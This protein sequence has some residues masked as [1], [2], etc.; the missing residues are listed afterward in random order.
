MLPDFGC[1]IHDLVFAPNNAGTISL[2]TQAVR[3]ALTTYERAHR[4]ARRRR[5]RSPP[6]QPNLLLIRVS[7]RIRANN[8]IGQSRLPVLHPRGRV[9]HAARASYLP[10][11]DDR[12]YDDIVAEIRTRIARYTPEWR[13]GESAW[14]D[15]NDSDPGITIAQVF[16]WQAEMLLYR[17]NKVPALN[18]I[19]FLELI[20]IELQPAEP[21]Q[22]EITFPLKADRPTPT[23]V[24]V[25]SRARSSRPIPATASRRSSS[26]PFAPLTA[27]RAP[28]DAVLVKE[29]IDYNDVS[30][31]NAD[32]THGFAPFGNTAPDGAELALGFNDPDPFPES[33]LDLAV[34]VQDRLRPAA[35]S[36]A[37]VRRR[38]L[39]LRRRSCT[40]TTGTAPRWV[41]LKLLKDD[42]LAFTRSGHVRL[43]LPAAGSLQKLQARADANRCTLLDS[44]GARPRAVRESAVD[45][46]GP[47]EHRRRQNRPRRCTTR[48]SAEAT[49][50]AIRP[51]SCRTHR[52]S[53]ARCGS[54]FSR[55]MSAS[56][57]GRRSR[58]SSVPDQPTRSTSSIARQ[59]TILFGDGVNGAIPVAYVNNP[60]ANVVA[61]E[62]T[63]RRWRARQC[64]GRR[65]QHAGDHRFR[66]STKAPSVTCRRRRAAATRKR[67]TTPNG[68]R[69]RSF[70]S[71]C[72]AV[73]VD[74][75][76]LLA[77]EAGNVRRAKALPLYDPRF[78][79]HAS[80][81]VVSVIV[82]PDSKAPNPMPSDGTLRTVCA[83]LDA[84]RLL[85]TELYVL[86]PSYQLIEIKG[87]VVA[88]DSADL[89]E[90]S[91]AIDAAL[92]RYF[93]PLNG[94]E[95]GERLAVR[96]NDLSTRASTSRCSLIDGVASI[97]E[98]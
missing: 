57:P 5:R 88:A 12:R 66:A 23:V 43:R 14:T 70:K 73:T 39:A 40:G 71:R 77:M 80:P 37:R 84:R 51:S 62:Y 48:C 34:I 81:G 4:R 1:G 61:R 16:A 69:P 18:Y 90:V 54:R 56:S 3:R 67:S 27:L 31:A 75:F 46:R 9:G 45:P 35:T 87:Q 24:I 25:P 97:S 42:S 21:A 26:R 17:L 7:Y 79:G 76:E 41:A 47:H 13:P 96:R 22:A 29:F 92:V 65:D 50:V 32:A 2:V 55:A 8:A 28:L 64:A 38:R 89:A 6:E 93:H 49:A 95:D 74:D 19:K 82:V 33:E 58:T 53:R 85:T 86:R 91:Q 10:A 20:G 36:S 15:V 44:R 98:R 52:C 60:G 78:P 94:G 63:G 11:I 68:E 30:Q 72:R 83:Y 59:A